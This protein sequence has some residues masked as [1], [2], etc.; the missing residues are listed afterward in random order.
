MTGNYFKNMMIFAVVV[1]ALGLETRAESQ[2]QVYTWPASSLMKTLNLQALEF[3]SIE[4]IDQLDRT[5]VLP[6]VK[7]MRGLINQA[8]NEPW[9]EQASFSGDVDALELRAANIESE[10]NSPGL[11]RTHI[12]QARAVI[13]DFH[14]LLSA[15]GYQE[16]YHFY[17]IRF[18][19]RFLK[20]E[21]AGLDD[22]LETHPTDVLKPA[23]ELLD[24]FQQGV[25]SDPAAAQI[26]ADQIKEVELIVRQVEAGNIQSGV[27]VRLAQLSEYY[28]TKLTDAG[29]QF[30]RW[31]P[32]DQFQLLAK[33]MDRLNASFEVF[34]VRKNVFAPVYSQVHQMTL[35]LIDDDFSSSAQDEKLRD[36]MTKYD[37]SPA[38]LP[39]TDTAD[40]RYLKE[41]SFY[42]FSISKIM[43]EGN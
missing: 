20:L 13:A 32:R 23:L 22:A 25:K 35:D 41:I 4:R 33:E 17:Y 42:M 38:E 40:Q 24:Y 9:V 14:Q 8:R 26:F 21:L 36:L 16:K 39:D 31:F 19:L 3:E 7:S 15:Q 18:G 43:F 10:M 2:E 11:T 29:I 5:L 1:T 6:A 37:H 28:D 12:R 27:F 30:D 34:R